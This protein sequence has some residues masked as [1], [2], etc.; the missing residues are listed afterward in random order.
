MEFL[1][2]NCRRPS[3]QMPLVLGA[4]DGCFPRLKRDIITS[5]R[6]SRLF[7]KGSSRVLSIN[8]WIN[9]ILIYTYLIL[10]LSRNLPCLIKIFESLHLLTVH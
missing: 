1:V 9:K 8:K 7:S 5:L 3:H 4:K 2:V 6:S 10:L